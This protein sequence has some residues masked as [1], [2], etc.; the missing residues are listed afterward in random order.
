MSGLQGFSAR[1]TRVPV[2]AIEAGEV[3]VPELVIDLSPHMS[4]TW[5]IE[6][7]TMTQDDSGRPLAL[8]ISDDGF[9]PLLPTVLI[10]LGL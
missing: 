9:S 6:G 7:L 2:S 5:N 3:L 4:L 10:A 8:M 1:L